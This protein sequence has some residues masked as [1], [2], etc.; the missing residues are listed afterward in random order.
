MHKNIVQHI[1]HYI[2]EMCKVLNPTLEQV[3]IY[4]SLIYLTIYFSLINEKKKIGFT[5]RFN[6][7]QN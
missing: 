7:T 1:K 2:I 6:D 5:H 4:Y 3:I